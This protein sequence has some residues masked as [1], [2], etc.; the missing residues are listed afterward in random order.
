MDGVEH[1]ERVERDLDRLIERR[2]EQR[3]SD[4]GELA[5]EQLWQESV[6]RYNRER[7]EE[8]RTAWLEYE[9]RLYRIHSGLA[10]EHLRRA[11]ELENGHLL[12][13]EST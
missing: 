8:H 2:H 5:A 12:Q 9:M 6:R 13:E 4:E 7:G 11:E 3:V 10:S 1:T